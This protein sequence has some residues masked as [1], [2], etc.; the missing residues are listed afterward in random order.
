MK[1][2]LL[3]SFYTMFNGH[4]IRTEGVIRTP[5]KA[6]CMQLLKVYTRPNPNVQ[7]LKAEC[8]PAG[9]NE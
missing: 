1:Y 2:L 7:R 8:V 9:E 6:T 3:V 5:S 4:Y